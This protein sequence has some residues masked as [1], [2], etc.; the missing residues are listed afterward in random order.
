VSSALDSV[1]ESQ[2]RLYRGTKVE[3]LFKKFLGDLGRDVVFEP[4]Y[5]LAENLHYVKRYIKE[6]DTEIIKDKLYAFFKLG[7]GYVRELV[8]PDGNYS[9]LLSSLKP[10]LPLL[11]RYVESR[12]MSS[13]LQNVLESIAERFSPGWI[14]GNNEERVN[15]LLYRLRYFLK[16]ELNDAHPL[17]FPKSR[18]VLFLPTAS[19]LLE[20]IGVSHEITHPFLDRFPWDAYVYIGDYYKEAIPT[21]VGNYSGLYEVVK[22]APNRLPEIKE[23]VG[24]HKGLH[25]PENRNEDALIDWSFSYYLGDE[26]TLETIEEIEAGKIDDVDGLVNKTLSNLRRCEGLSELFDVSSLVLKSDIKTI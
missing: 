13:E 10:A 6:L 25:S 16:P 3:K 20:I 19:D 5:S 23:F 11:E 24:Y 8:N 1:T 7:R 4:T 17:G 14:I 2:R 21:I 26:R 15:A 22:N 9:G 18:I 12:T